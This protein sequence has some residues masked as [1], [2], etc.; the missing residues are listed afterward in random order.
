MTAKGLLSYFE[1]Y[2]GEKYSG[3]FLDTMISY[4]DGYSENFLQTAAEVIIKRFPRIYNK[5]PDVSVFESNKNEI[6]DKMPNPK[7]LPKP[8]IQIHTI[9]EIEQWD[10]YINTL[11]EK[12]GSKP[13]LAKVIDSMG[14]C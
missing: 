4:L 5:V 3:I 2:Y 8:E 11:K 10:M 13:L 14:S 12:F 1:N 9:Q 6:F 7:Q